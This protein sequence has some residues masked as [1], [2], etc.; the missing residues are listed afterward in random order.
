M[1]FNGL[2]EISASWA[3]ISGPVA[4]TTRVCAYDRAGQGWSETADAPPGRHRRRPGPAHPARRRRR[5]RP[6]RPGRALDRRHLRHDLRRPLPRAGRRHGAPGQLQ[7]RPAHQD[8]RLRR[9]VRRDAPRPRAAAHPGPARPGPAVP[10]LR[11]CPAPAADQVDALTSTAT[12]SPQRPRRALGRPRR[13]RPGPGTDHAR[14][15]AARG[16]HRLRVPHRRR[17]GRRPGPARRRSRPTTSTA[18]CDSTHAGLL[19]D[20]D[21]AAE[22][23]RAITEVIT[24]VRTGTPLDQ[25]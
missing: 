2:G 3:R 7:P 5:D 25:K 16:A 11:T 10:R 13:L 17:L 23:V 18:P 14:R 22:S 24:A 15:P 9:P 8:R 20:A 21:P 6:L 1:L 19:E 12:R 4:E